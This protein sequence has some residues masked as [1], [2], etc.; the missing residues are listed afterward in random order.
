MVRYFDK[1]I[2]SD[3]FVFLDTV[4]FE[5]NS[6][7]NRNQILS[8]QGPVWLTIPVKTKGHL[9]SSLQETEIDNTQHWQK[10][11]LKSIELTYKKASFF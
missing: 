1:L 7:I 2:R 11:H 10:K 3:V 5:K 4:Q 9:T 6:F 8:K